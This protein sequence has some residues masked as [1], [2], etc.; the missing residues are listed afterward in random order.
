MPILFVI[1]KGL[2]FEKVDLKIEIEKCFLRISSQYKKQ[3]IAEIQRQLSNNNKE[4]NLEL[5]KE[6]Q[7]L[8][9][10]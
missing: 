1:I 8:M 6:L 3:R 4:N 9:K 7:N 2:N 5:L 10:K